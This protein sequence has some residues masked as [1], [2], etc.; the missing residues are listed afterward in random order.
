MGLAEDDGRKCRSTLP[1][2]NHQCRDG[3]TSP[4][5]AAPAEPVMICA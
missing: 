3:A 1:I 2:L 5:V 4:D